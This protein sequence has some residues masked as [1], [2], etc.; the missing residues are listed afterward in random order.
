MP[1]SSWNPE[2]VLRTPSASSVSHR[3]LVILNQPFSY[4]LLSVL[5]N[6]TAWR[7]CADGGANRLH[8]VSLKEGLARF[9]PDVVRGD[10]DSLRPDVR[11]AYSALGIPIEHDPDQYST[12]LM[13]C[14]DVVPSH[15]T[16][17][18]LLGGLSGRL[19]QTVHV[20]A[21]LHRKRHESRRMFAITDDS[22]GW[23]LDAGEH[24]I[25]LPWPIANGPLGPTC[26]ILPVGVAGTTLTTKG[27]EWDVEDWPSSF[28]GLVS[29]SNHIASGTVRVRTTAPVWWTVE[30]R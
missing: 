30:V 1:T 14:L 29:T 22:L 13:K 3:A 7:A 28:D 8:D 6:A 16:E 4:E 17:V 20:L 11:E 19:D 10:L 15:V 12:D 23:V 24:E 25:S 9:K 27:L 2:F 26:G 5:W 21:L 18:V